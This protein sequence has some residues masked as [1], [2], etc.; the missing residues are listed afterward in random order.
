MDDSSGCPVSKGKE[1][2]MEKELNLE[3]FMKKLAGKIEKLVPDEYAI[4]ID[5]DFRDSNDGTKQPCIILQHID[6]KGFKR[7]KIFY[8]ARIYELEYRESEYSIDDIAHELVKASEGAEKALSYEEVESCRTYE[9]ARKK[10]YAVLNAASPE[11]M[12]SLDSQD[13]IYHRILDMVVTYAVMV[14]SERSLCVDSRLLREWGITEDQLYRDTLDNYCNIATPEL[15]DMAMGFDSLGRGSLLDC[16]DYLNSEDMP[17]DI[18]ELLVLSDTRRRNSAA[19]VLSREVMEKVGKLIG[20]DFY[21]LPSS[22]HEMLIP[23]MPGA[24]VENLLPMVVSV[25]SEEVDAVDRLTDSVYRYHVAEK[26][27]ELVATANEG[28]W[29]KTYSYASDK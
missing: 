23:D 13:I 12:H 25:N 6:D 26:T 5:M 24:T 16:P 11:M 10:L 21:L 9:Y 18:G 4:S 3:E 17:D 22:K 19:V 7:R 14:G 1:F 2:Y 28:D 29:D 27:L 15:R 8:C 20:H